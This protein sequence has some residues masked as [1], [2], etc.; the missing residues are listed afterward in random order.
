MLLYL[1]YAPAV[2]LCCAHCIGVQSGV[3][4]FTWNV[5]LLY[6]GGQRE[7][8]LLITNLTH[9]YHLL[10][11]SLYMFRA[12][13]CSSSGNWIVLMH[14]LVWLVC[15]SDCLVSWSGGNCS[16][17]LTGIPSSHLHRLII[18]DDVLIQFSS[19]LTGIPSSHLHGLII[20]DDVLI[21]FSSLL[22]G[23]PSSHLYWLIIPDDVLI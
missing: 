4:I 6:L 5:L 8:F 19:L 11:S 15:V 12:S 7:W 2:I 18:P 3:I 20:P 17:L 22:T 1:R 23:I 14:H 13:R 21:Q 10:I 9:F 16:Y